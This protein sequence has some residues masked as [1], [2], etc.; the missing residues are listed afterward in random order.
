MQSEVDENKTWVASTLPE[1]KKAIKTKWVF[2]IKNE[3][4]GSAR[5]KAEISLCVLRNEMTEK[6]KC[7]ASSLRLL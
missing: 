5:Y 3:A 2:K 4:D 6:Q 1:D 7:M